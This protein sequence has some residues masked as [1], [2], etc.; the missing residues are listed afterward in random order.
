MLNHSDDVC[1]LEH[2]GMGDRM[3]LYSAFSFLSSFT[4]ST[5]WIPKSPCK[6]FNY[7]THNR[8][9]PLD[10]ETPWSDY[11]ALPK[12]VKPWDDTETIK[13]SHLR[14]V[15]SYQYISTNPLWLKNREKVF[16]GIIPGHKIE[17]TCTLTEGLIRESNYIF[18]HIRRGD[19]KRQ[20][21][22]ATSLDVMLPRVQRLQKTANRSHILYSTNPPL[23]EADRKYLSEVTSAFKQLDPNAIYV[24]D[25]LNTRC[26]TDNYCTICR[27]YK[28][29]YQAPHIKFRQGYTY[30][31]ALS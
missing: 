29:K 11:F 5:V 26:K 16:N 6:A 7:K 18:V 25:I 1:I 31:E 3:F 2:A 12:N 27:I 19:F 28:L 9:I 10:C 23:N 21:E 22:R 20:K 4:N 13:C 30:R 15:E 24:D 14:N 8:G 17:L